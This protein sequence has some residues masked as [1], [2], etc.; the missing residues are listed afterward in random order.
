MGRQ[1][2]GWLKYLDEVSEKVQTEALLVHMSREFTELAFGN[3]EYP[4][5]CWGE[6]MAFLDYERLG[7][8]LAGGA[9]IVEA[10]RFMRANPKRFEHFVRENR[11]AH[12]AS[13]LEAAVSTKGIEVLDL[14]I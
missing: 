6:S 10:M 12:D 7:L 4:G 13:Q 3:D 11:Q 8:I 2:R 9:V 14:G 1:K 5:G